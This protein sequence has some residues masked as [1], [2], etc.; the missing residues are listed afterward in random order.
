[1]RYQLGELGFEN[2][3]MLQEGF[4]EAITKK[5]IKFRIVET[6]KNNN[7][8]NEAAVEDGVLYIQV[9]I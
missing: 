1:M 4:A 3:S 6:L 8:Y 5:T 2:D 9:R 7:D